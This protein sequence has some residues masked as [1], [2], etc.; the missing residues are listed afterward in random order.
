[1]LA[2]WKLDALL[3][4]GKRAAYVC[5]NKALASHIQ[6]TNTT[7]A[8]AVKS[9]DA[10]FFELKQPSRGSVSEESYFSE[11]IPNAI[12]D[13]SVDLP[14][15]RK[16]DAIVV[17]EGQDF[18][19]SRLM[20]LFCLLREGGQW[21][22]LADLAQDVYRRN[23][24][25]L[26]G[27]EVTFRMF[28]NC[29]NTELINDATNSYC[30]QSVQPMPGVSRGALPEVILCSSESGMAMRAWDA[31]KRL[32]PEGGA[33]FLSPYKLENSCMNQAGSGYGLKLSQD[34]KD[35]GTNG[36]VYFST[37]RSFKGLEARV[38]ILLHGEVPERNPS[39]MRADLYVACTR[40]TGRL[41]IL[42]R[43]KEA[44]DWFAR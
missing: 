26:L 2:L 1:M 6:A 20:A 30:A 13:F 23:A 34:I 35:L 9:V 3:E 31:V 27:T 5:F 40:S 17:D 44:L 12:L 11:V 28:H 39:L 16:Y 14:V 42:T 32:S 10:L 15:D 4:E 36:F 22:V 25:D 19:D 37:I 24:Q 21:L 7:I 33:V 41:V 43:S 18:G 38:V 29:R 8:H